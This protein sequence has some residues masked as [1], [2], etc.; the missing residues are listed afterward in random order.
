MLARAVDEQ[1]RADTGGDGALSRG[2]SLGRADVDVDAGRTSA[3]VSGAGSIGLWALLE[4]GSRGHTVTA[5]RGRVLAT[6]YG[7]RPQ[8]KVSGVPARRTWSKGV[9]AGMELV[10][11]DADKAWSKVGR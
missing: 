1:L 10:E 3:D 11:R 5:E 4:H 2:K 8:V 9:E 7:P 6:P